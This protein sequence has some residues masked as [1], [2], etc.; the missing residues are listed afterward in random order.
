MDFRTGLAMQYQQ[1]LFSKFPLFFRSVLYP[2]AYP[3]NLALLGIR[4]G[5][6][7]YS[8]IEEA[9]REI[10]QELNL[11]W[12]NQVRVPQ[13]IASLDYDVLRPLSPTFTSA[14]PIMHFCSDIHGASG[15]LEISVVG[16]YLCHPV[17]SRRIEEIIKGAQSRAR[18]ACERCG[19]P[20]TF[21]EGYWQH[22]YC[23][24]CIAPKLM[25]DSFD[26]EVVT[27]NL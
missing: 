1:K 2:A 3:S 24:E 14:Y 6:G 15:R 17:T 27:S 21:R 23:D 9:A 26:A 22:V 18:T 19:S 5:L 25:P 10:E 16:G 8:V 4:C 7:W 13:N 12:C 11:E 20:G